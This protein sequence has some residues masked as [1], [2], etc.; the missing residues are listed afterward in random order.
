MK[1]DLN[2][3]IICLILESNVHGA[4]W[5][6]IPDNFQITSEPISEINNA[7][8]LTNNATLNQ[9]GVRIRFTVLSNTDFKASVG[10]MIQYANY[11]IL[12]ICPRN[13]FPRW[14]DLE[15]HFASQ[16]SQANI[17][18]NCFIVRL[19]IRAQIL[20]GA[21]DSIIAELP[22]VPNMHSTFRQYFKSRVKDDSSTEVWISSSQMMSRI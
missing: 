22:F 16:L 11:K 12:V 6:N 4:F 21:F 15:Q 14:N 5:S 10:N 7:I 8:A 3:V 18:T 2:L 9:T 13:I 19:K 20:D 1:T 17:S